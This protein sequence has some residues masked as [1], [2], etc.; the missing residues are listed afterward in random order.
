MACRYGELA[1]PK[2]KRNE[3]TWDTSVKGTEW[4]T[5]TQGIQ[6]IEGPGKIAIYR[7]PFCRPI[8]H[9]NT[10]KSGI[11]SYIACSAI[12]LSTHDWRVE[13][14]SN[15]HLTIPDPGHSI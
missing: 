2:S 3:P 9:A 7:V 5:T 12:K 8:A 11:Q 13:L 1:T 6:A 14:N 4:R 10:F 15:Q